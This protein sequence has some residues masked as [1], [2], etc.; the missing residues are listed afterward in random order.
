MLVFLLGAPGAGKG[1]QARRLAA[2]LSVPH[3]EMSAVLRHAISQ[4]G[5]H[6][7]EFE[8]AMSAGGPLP[9]AFVVDALL[10]R[11]REVDAE[12]GAVV[13]AFPYTRGQ[14]ERFDQRTPERPRA[15]YLEGSTEILRARIARRRAGAAEAA[16]RP[17][18][19]SD[20]AQGRIERYLERIPAALDYYRAAGRLR[21]VEADRSE[22]AVFGSVLRAVESPS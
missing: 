7:D 2:H 6:G 13:D 4:S 22:D 9:D 19:A 1:T 8:R 20:F 11:L 12:H 14:A 21:V 16:L 17:D 15:V 10:A 3:I 5:E 18:D